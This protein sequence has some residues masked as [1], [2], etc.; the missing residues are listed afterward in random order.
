MKK[1][2]CVIGEC[3]ME[4]TN[5]ENT[6]YDQ[7]IAGDTLNFSSY[8]NKKI[9]KT[10]YL[11]AIGTSDISKKVINFLNKE[12][13][14][15]NLVIRIPSYEIGLYL[16][17]NN[18]LGEKRFYYWRDNSASKFFFNNLII[19]DLEQKLENFQYVYFTGITLSLFENTSI[20]N[21]IEVIDFLKK[22][23]IQIIFDLNIRIKR[24]SRKNLISYL[25]K[26]LPK[27][28]TLF[29]SGEDLKFWK[30]SN[31]LIIF[32][33]VLRKYKI[34]HGVF[35]KN[36]KYNYSFYDNKQYTIKN[37][38]LKKVIDS[39]GAG[40]GYN[41]TYLS[42]FMNYQNPKK[43]LEAASRTGAKIVMKKGAIVDV[44]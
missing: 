17:K 8:L 29:A 12:K 41:A 39:S 33:N 11:T 22:K 40:D 34:T 2:I 44:R 37:K 16:I 31:N 6:L 18:T 19:K 42:S 3:M 10:Y 7:S 14:N 28:D 24:W 5:L 21:F 38:L 36:A 27:I 13:I 1:K 4:F 32:E 43:A 23:N 35:R 15:S 25:S 26:I 9:F 20:D 30:G